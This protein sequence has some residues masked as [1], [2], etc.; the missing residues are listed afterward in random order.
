[1][2]L[3]RW[4]AATVIVC[5]YGLW[6]LAQSDPH[7]SPRWARDALVGVWTVA[8]AVAIAYWPHL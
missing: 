8:A 2:T 1:M 7:P 4:A 3:H 6:W 5:A